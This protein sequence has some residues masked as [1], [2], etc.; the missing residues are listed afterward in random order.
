M[1]WYLIISDLGKSWHVFKLEENLQKH[2]VFIHSFV[3][4]CLWMLLSVLHWIWFYWIRY[5]FFTSGLNTQTFEVLFLVVCPDCLTQVAVVTFYAIC[6]LLA[7]FHY[8]IFAQIQHMFALTLITT[9][10]LT[11]TQTNGGH[12]EFSWSTSVMHC[13]ICTVNDSQ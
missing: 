7:N 6:R 10:F 5:N 4:V 2:H 1:Y 13:D 12:F 11:S 3:R 9:C 8:A